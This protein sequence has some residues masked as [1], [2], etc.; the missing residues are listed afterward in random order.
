MPDAFIK[1][2]RGGDRAR[3]EEKLT[4]PGSLVYPCNGNGR[5]GDTPGAGYRLV[6]WVPVRHTLHRWKLYACQD[7]SERIRSLKPGLMPQSGRR[8]RQVEKIQ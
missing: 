5:S 4:R 1:S 2:R 7:V 3:T 8:L 6:E